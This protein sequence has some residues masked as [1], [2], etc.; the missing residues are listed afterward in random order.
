MKK[1]LI[2][3]TAI[4]L[5]FTACNADATS[6]LFRTATQAREA[7]NIQYTQIIGR[8]AANTNLYFL[9]K[10]GLFVKESNAKSSSLILRSVEGNRIQRAAYLS[11]TKILIKTDMD[12]GS[13]FEFN[14]LT[15]IK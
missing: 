14:P 13:L 12:N 6:G 1:T 15:K 9:T 8:E 4:T 10:E 2:I 7:I 5:L 3:I 11:A